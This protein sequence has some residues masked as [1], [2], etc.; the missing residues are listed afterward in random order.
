MLSSF[1]VTIA[2]FGADV[3]L[4]ALEDFGT[5]L[6]FRHGLP[7]GERV[8]RRFC[9]PLYTSFPFLI[10]PHVLGLPQQ[11]GMLPDGFLHPRV[12][13]QQLRGDFTLIVQER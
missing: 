4:E 2:L 1:S 12:L 3:D 11:P 10:L 9:R 5:P 7:E 8:E 13:C 6:P